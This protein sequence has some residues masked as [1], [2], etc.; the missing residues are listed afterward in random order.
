[1]AQGCQWDWGEIQADAWKSSHATVRGSAPL[2]A[3]P[4]KMGEH[5]T[6]TRLLVKGLDLRV[7][8]YTTGSPVPAPGQAEQKSSG[9]VNAHWH[10]GPWGLKVG[11][12]AEGGRRGQGS[13]SIAGS[14]QELSLLPG[15]QPVPAL[16]PQRCGGGPV[17]S[18]QRH[19]HN[20]A[21]T[22]SS[23]LAHG[24]QSWAGST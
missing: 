13:H 17:P 16:W 22:G 10:L 12:W 11:Q 18:F 6:A 8:T 7:P 21:L 19:P 14:L 9:M 2:L 5:R 24:S 4:P 15:S 1:M 23:T 20:P 3:G